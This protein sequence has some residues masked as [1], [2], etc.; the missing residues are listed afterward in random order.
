[1]DHKPLIAIEARVR[2]YRSDRQTL[3]PWIADSQGV[4][5]LSACRKGLSNAATQREVFPG[6]ADTVGGTEAVRLSMR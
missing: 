3:A 6:V 2:R 1:M 4:N 5:E